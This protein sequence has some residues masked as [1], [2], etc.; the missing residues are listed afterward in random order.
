MAHNK[1]NKP[2]GR[3][4]LRDVAKESGVSV[5]TVSYVLNDSGSVGNKVKEQVRS[6]INRLGYTPNFSAQAI[7]T[8]RTKTLGII[9]PDLK[10][11]FFPELAQSVESAA[12]D[13]GFAVF[14]VDTQESV[15]AEAEGISKL[16][17]HGVEGI[18]WCPSS[19]KDCFKKY[20]GSIPVVVI[21]R[22]LPNY[23]TV[24]S[25]YSKGG[26][27]LAQ[28]LLSEGHRKIGLISG[29]QT[30]ESAAQRR[31]GFLEEIGIQ[32]EIIWEIENPF[33]IKLC[34]EA[35]S[36]LKKQAVSVIVAGNDMIAIGA[37]KTLN[38]LKINVPESVSVVGFDDVPWSDIVHP[39]LT[40]IR[41]PLSELGKEAVNLLLR[42]IGNLTASKKSVI[43]D[44]QL[45]V[46]DSVFSLK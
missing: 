27:L 17:K 19:E 22:P 21:D 18:I 20:A 3:V 44:V 11:P 14:L 28:Y 42:R 2:P 6:T 8:G 24:Y 31:K 45:V 35:V 33:S 15:E 34:P 30:I 41:Q 16:I 40:T 12:R 13:S 36:E 5:A 38:K 37:I 4:T 29:P 10:N 46:R 32:A 7:R 26:K 39:S 1:N 23:D 9:I 43:L 25:D